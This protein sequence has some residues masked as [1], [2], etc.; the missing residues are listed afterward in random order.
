M[1]LSGSVV[2]SVLFRGLCWAPLSAEVLSIASY[3]GGEETFLL[4]SGPPFRAAFRKGGVG[5]DSSYVG[6]GKTFLVFF[7]LKPNWA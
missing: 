4:F 6:G 1:S 7:G 5:S 3:V 2:D